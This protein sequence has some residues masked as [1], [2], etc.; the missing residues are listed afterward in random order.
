MT[1]P[2]K[3]VRYPKDLADKL[4]MLAILSESE[5]GVDI[6]DRLTRKAVEGE[7]ARLPDD[8]RALARCSG[9]G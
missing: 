4:R 3:L 7:F 2:T 8:V 5:S 6:L 1:G 9:A